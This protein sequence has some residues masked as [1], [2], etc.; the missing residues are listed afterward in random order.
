MILSSGA[1]EIED[2]S[3]AQWRVR[4]LKMKPRSGSGGERHRVESVVLVATANHTR[5]TDS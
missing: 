1:S 4:D 3:L 2:K 5:D